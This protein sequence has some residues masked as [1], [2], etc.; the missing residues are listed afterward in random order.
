MVSYLENK[1]CVNS[2]KGK[3]RDYY[4][5]ELMGL[6]ILLQIGLTVW[7]GV[8]AYHTN[9]YRYF[10]FRNLRQNGSTQPAGRMPMGVKISI[11]YIVYFYAVYINR[12]NSG[13]FK[14]YSTGKDLRAFAVRKPM[15]DY[16][17]DPGGLS[18]NVQTFV[19]R[20]VLSGYH[21]SGYSSG[22]SF[23]GAEACWQNGHDVSY[24]RSANCW[25]N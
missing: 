20:L 9:R 12:T 13:K 22:D 7:E 19:F 25:R 10:S 23:N 4:S 16:E 6:I 21:R 1:N 2:Y 18:R 14:A 24:H 15:V 3:K 17:T 5:N 11:F 8:R